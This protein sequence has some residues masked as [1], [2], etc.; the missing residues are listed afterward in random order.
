MLEL[1]ETGCHNINLVTPTPYLPQIHAALEIATA[2]GL[3]R[4]FLI[5]PTKITEFLQVKA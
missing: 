1:Q 3:K 4:I 2:R 5:S